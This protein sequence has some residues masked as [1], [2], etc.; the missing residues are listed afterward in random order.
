[1]GCPLLEFVG[2]MGV[3]E[4]ERESGSEMI[5]VWGGERARLRVLGDERAVGLMEGLR[6]GNSVFPAV[7]RVGLMAMPRV[8]WVAGGK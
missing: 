5:V 8:D 1:M 4:G 2:G 6:E 3:K 7:G